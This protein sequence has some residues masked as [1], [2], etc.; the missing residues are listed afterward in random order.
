ITGTTEPLSF[1]SQPYPSETLLEAVLSDGGICGGDTLVGTITCPV[2]T[3]AGSMTADTVRVCG[4]NTAVVEA[5]SGYGIDGNDTLVYVL[6]DNATA[7]LGTILGISQIPEFAFYEAL[8]FE[9]TYFISAVVG[10]RTPDGIDFSDPFL[11]VSA[12]TPVIFHQVP[13]LEIGGDQITCPYDTAWVDLEYSGTLP[14]AFTYTQNESETVL[15]INEFG[16]QIAIVDS[17]YVEPIAVSTP[18]CEGSVSGSVQV[19]HHA[20]PNAVVSGTDNICEGDTA[21]LEI[22]FQ[23]SAPFSYSLSENSEVNPVQTTASSTVGFLAQVEGWYA[24]VSLSDA[25]CTATDTASKFLEV[26][27]I[28]SIHLDSEHQV[29]HL[30]TL[31]LALNPE[32]GQTFEWPESPNLS[33]LGNETLSFAANTAS[34]FVL[35]ESFWITTSLNGCTFA[36]TLTFFTHPLPNTQ[37]AGGWEVCTNDSLSLIGF[38]GE[39]YLWE[40]ATHFSDTTGYQ[41]WFRAASPAEIKLTAFS[42]VG[43]KSSITDSIG[44]L[45]APVSE[46]SLSQTEGCAPLELVAQVSQ[47]ESGELFRWSSEMH[48]SETA[49]PEAS[50]VF[51]EPG[52]YTVA[53]EVESENGCKSRAVWP[54]DVNVFSTYADF[55]FEAEDISVTNPEVY[56]RNTSPIDVQSY[57]TIDTL[58][59]F[60]G[61]NANF[62][63]PDVDGGTYEVCLDVISE[64]GCLDSQCREV[65]VADDFFIYAPN[66]FTPNGDGLNDLFGPVLSKIDLVDYRF[67]IVDRWGKKVFDTRDRT[68]KWDG[69]NSGDEHYGSN[70]VYIWHLVAKPDFNVQTR[71]YTGQIMLI[72]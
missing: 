5:S 57:W 4:E 25:N 27:P 39:T 42:A 6:H 16:A 50:F 9:E 71:R 12:G 66:S 34:P 56:F 30:D 63:F 21:A 26:R 32:P 38:G 35:E 40:P 10:N 49:A 19:N 31:Q 61:R 13:F 43:C 8:S 58:A 52:T 54:E 62:S 1:S 51:E 60:D 37:I 7:Q 55:Y 22:T 20:L 47:E 33:F 41:T 53:L 67:W 68:K 17:G 2:I 45:E 28:P 46:F 69:S 14:Y 44:V 11:S 24:V 48:S 72:R 3:N 70:Q 65:V 64:N 36:D 15:E 59:A 18:F 29:C 23:G